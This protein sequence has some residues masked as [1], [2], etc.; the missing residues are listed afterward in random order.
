MRQVLIVDAKH[1]VYKYVKA[2]YECSRQAHMW[3]RFERRKQRLLKHSKALMK[4]VHWLIGK[5]IKE[6]DIGWDVWRI[7]LHKS[8][9]LGDWD[10]DRIEFEV[11]Q[12]QEGE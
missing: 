11:V 5:H 2:A 10:M 8:Y 12:V 1:N 6:N 7:S 9:T 4:H 3:Y